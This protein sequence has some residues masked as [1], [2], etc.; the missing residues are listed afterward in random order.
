MDL[1]QKVKELSSKHS[2]TVVPIVFKDEDT[3]EEVI[4]FIKAPSRMVKLRIMDKA[5]TGVI[6]ASAELFDAILLT[7]E[8]DARF[9]SGKSVDDKFYLG[10]A[11]AAY[12]TI[13]ISVNQF[14]KK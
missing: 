5:Q 7:E 2:C 12:D 4:G 13:K 8:S 9:S 11:M 3:E 14:K 6:T 10:G 1:E